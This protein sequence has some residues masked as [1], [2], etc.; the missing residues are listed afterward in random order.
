MRVEF[1]AES[2]LILIWGSNAI[3]SSVHFWRHVQ[4]AKRNG[5]TIIC[6]DPRRSETAEKCH[7]HIALLPGTDAALALGLMQRAHYV[8]DWL[9]HDYIARHTLGWDALRARALEWT[10]ERTAAVCGITAATR[11]R[12]WRAR[13]GRPPA[14]ASLWPSA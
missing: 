2:Q 10:P 5:A 12:N 6:I 13:T 7:Q 11:C 8:H 3:A 9:D 4:T 14:Q 1:F